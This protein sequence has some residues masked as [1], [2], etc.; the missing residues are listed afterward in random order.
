MTGPDLYFGKIT[1]AA[2]WTWTGGDTPWAGR[3]PMQ[4]RSDDGLKRWVIVGME[5]RG[6]TQR[7]QNQ[8]F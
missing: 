6:S 1:L 3:P 5:R 2:A 8:S 7:R 4:A